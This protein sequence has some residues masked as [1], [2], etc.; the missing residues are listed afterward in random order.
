MSGALDP[1]LK[2][3]E[4]QNL[5]LAEEEDDRRPSKAKEQLERQ[6][7]WEEALPFYFCVWNVTVITP[8]S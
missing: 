5:H 8:L 6:D 3:P 7:S 1:M 2:G 4:G